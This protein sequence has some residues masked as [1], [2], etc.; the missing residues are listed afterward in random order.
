MSSGNATSASVLDEAA[1]APPV[2][3]GARVFSFVLPALAAI[4]YP[5]LLSAIAGLLQF[6]QVTAPPGPAAITVTVLAI[7]ASA[8]AVMGIAFARALSMGHAGGPAAPRLLAHLAF[9][10]PTLLVAFG[11][12]VGLFHARG[13]LTYVWP[14]FWLA[15]TCVT[16]L[17]QEVPRPALIVSSRR[18]AVAH[19]I[20][21]LAILILFLVPH[22]GNHLT[23]IVS[24]A[25]HVGVMKL[26]R[27]V[28]RNTLIEPLLITLIAFQIMSG[29]VLVRRRL[30][31][32]NDFFGTLQT[33]TGIYVGCYFLGHMTAVFAARGA[34]TDTNWNW[35]TSGDHGL[36]FHLSSFSLVGHYWVGPIAI[37]THAACGLRMVML[38][39]GMSEHAAA[40]VAWGLI[41]L[42]TLG[43]S[44]ILAGLL[45]AHIA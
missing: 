36:L 27:L 39:H 31:H 13:A 28:Y 37:V 4:A 14:L 11:N 43:S 5:F 10:V 7:L 19:G 8:L 26:V 12:V 29:F 25:D 42:G 2:A 9:A 23:G 45:G 32:A 35:L 15:L 40:R 6:F 1:K 44:V 41:G 21:A 16:W 22:L 34:G 18:L 3:S 33:M 30:N 20:S 17:A 38:G 24:G